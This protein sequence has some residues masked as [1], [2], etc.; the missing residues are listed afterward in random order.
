M[1]SRSREAGMYLILTEKQ[2]DLAF[3]V[4]LC[5]CLENRFLEFRRQS[6]GP[7]SCSPLD[8]EVVDSHQGFCSAGGEK[9]LDPTYLHL[10]LKPTRFSN[11]GMNAHFEKNR[12]HLF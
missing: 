10:V 4:L 11:L 1:A 8:R 3:K 5:C 7:V 6:R 2:H 12:P 9:W